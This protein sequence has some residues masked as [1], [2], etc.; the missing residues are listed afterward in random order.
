MNYRISQL[1]LTPNNKSK[2]F[3]DVY[4]AQPDATKESLVGKLFILI[5]IESNK[6]ESLKAINFLIDNINH[7]YYQNEKVILREKLSSLKVEHIFETTLAKTN[8]NFSEFIKNE[9][10]KMNPNALNITAG[11][12]YEDSIHFANAGKN[13][14]FL[15]YLNKKK[16]E[17]ESGYKIY[18]ILQK[19]KMLERNEEK[20]FG[21]VISGKIPPKG[22]FIFSNEALPE[23]ISQNQL[24]EIITNLPPNSSVEQM[25]NILSNI[26]AYVSFLGVI[27]KSSTA[28]VPSEQK[29]IYSTQESISNLQRT[30]EKTES[31]LTPSGMTSPRKWLKLPR[32]AKS[33]P[34]QDLGAIGLK[35]K[36]FMKKNPILKL[37]GVG[38]TLKNLFSYLLGF[39]AWIF[40]SFSSREK[41]SESLSSISNGTKNGL[42]KVNSFYTNLSYKNK[43]FLTLFIVI[44]IIFAV[45]TLTVKN[46]NEKIESQERYNNLITAIKQKQDKLEANLL[47][48]NTEGASELIK[49]IQKLLGEMPRET[50]EQNQEYS[51]ISEKLNEQLEKISNVVR[52]DDSI[53]LANF[54]NLNNTANSANIN[55]LEKLNKAYAGDADQNSIY[56]FDTTNNVAT[57]L[58]DLKENSGFGLSTRGNENNIFYLSGENIVELSADTET[59]YNLSIDTTNDTKNP[60]AM[61]SYNGRIYTLNRET[62][63]IF[64]FNR[65]GQSFASPA[66]WIKTN[67]DLSESVDLSIDGHIYILLKNGDVLKFLKGEEQE[68]SMDEV[69]PSIEE[70]TKLY[71]SPELKFIYILEPKNKRLV[72]YDKTGKFILQYKADKFDNLKDFAVDEKNQVIYFLNGNTVYKAEAKHF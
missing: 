36:I 29:K 43:I 53:E 31:I 64:R 20:L 44:V 12:I 66:P 52:V 22:S 63:Q 61:D 58:A 39:F 1:T 47:Y 27:I 45:N 42:G 32:F 28:E 14:A 50:E 19:Q 9:K 10:I 59:I 7:N 23:Y 21:N 2:V 51:S 11:V 35:D 15:I 5:E 46:N 26:N 67:V 70:A 4:I 30:E 72:I 38:A 16:D 60:V 56:V 37:G 49:E 17:K 57:T 54:S 62:N 33:Q 8:K 18:N 25:K 41:M 68:L 40:K 65:S 6:A 13:K 34:S 48:N 69:G 55:F 71:V 3:G 24:I